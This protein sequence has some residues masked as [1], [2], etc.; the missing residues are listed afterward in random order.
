M[1]RS[2]QEV[3]HALHE[4]STK[5]PV[6]P[7]SDFEANVRAYIEKWKGVIRKNGPSN[8]KNNGKKLL[9]FCPNNVMCIVS[10]RNRSMH[11]YTWYREACAQK[12]MIDLIP[13]SFDLRRP[14][15]DVLLKESQSCQAIIPCRWH[16]TL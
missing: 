10:T 6:V 4:V 9:R 8:L 13:I 7:T 2:L 1:S 3:E 15:T 12:S 5:E 11:Q 14:A 16:P